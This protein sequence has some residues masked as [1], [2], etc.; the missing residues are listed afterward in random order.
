MPHDP[1]YLVTAAFNAVMLLDTGILGG[2]VTPRGLILAAW[3]GLSVA[4]AYVKSPR[5]D[6]AIGILFV[7]LFAV[8]IGQFGL[9][10]GS[11]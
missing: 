2:H 8:F 6:A 3:I 11:L 10:L 4:G 5:Y 1:F 9:R 7:L